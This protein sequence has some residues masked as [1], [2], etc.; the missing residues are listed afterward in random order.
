MSYLAFS[1]M[2]AEDAPPPVPV[3]KAGSI[4]ASETWSGL[5]QVTADVKIETAA[6]VTIAPGTVVEFMGNF[7]LEVLGDIQAVGNASQR[8]AFRPASGV[9]S[10]YGI[11][12]GA[13][14]DGFTWG[15]A[16]LGENPRFQFCDFVDGSKTT[17]VT[18]GDRHNLRGGAIG[19]NQGDAITIEDCTF[20]RCKAVEQA[21]AVYINGGNLNKSYALRRCT[22][23]DC[24]GNFAAAFKL[25]HGASLAIESCTISGSVIS[26]ARFHDIPI[27]VN[28]ANDTFTAPAAHL[29][30]TASPV[31]IIGGT[32]PGGVNINQTYFAIVVSSTEFKIAETIAQAKAGTAVNI[33]SD[34]AGV[35]GDAHHDWFVFDATVAIS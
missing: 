31:R 18:I 20:T 34:G 12:F 27:S 22:F 8:I 28:A 3:A 15:T 13:N 7:W 4:A 33:T 5:I 30:I 32:V 17:K 14:I 21:G 9:P 11:I 29:L 1:G 26:D 35:K 2:V 25:D 23:T 19:Y 24:E 16:K 6:T 10:W